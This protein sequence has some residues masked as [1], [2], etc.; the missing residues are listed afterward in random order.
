M[1]FTVPE[2]AA[3]AALQAQRIL[4]TQETLQDMLSAYYKV[5]LRACASCRSLQCYMTR[6]IGPTFLKEFKVLIVNSEG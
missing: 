5:K 3:H 1:G 2:A 4:L 6:A